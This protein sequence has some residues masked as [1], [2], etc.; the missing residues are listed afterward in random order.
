M[1]QKHILH[2]IPHLGGGLGRVIFAY[3][4]EE[5]KQN[6]NIHY[7]LTLEETKNAVENY[8]DLK[9]YI[10]CVNWRNEIK[11]IKSYINFADI[12]VIH[13]FNHP[14]LFDFMVNFKFLFCRLICY[15]HVSSIFYP[16]TMP[17]NF[18]TFFDKIVFTTAASM[19]IPSVQNFL[20]LDNKKFYVIESAFGAEYVNSNISKPKDEFIIGYI[21]T[22]NHSKLHPNFIYMCSLVKSPVKFVICSNDPQDL[23]KEEIKKFNI[24]DKFYLEGKVEDVKPYLEKFH[25]F[26]YPLQPQHFGSAEQAL[27]ESM[28][29]KAVPIV[30][31]NLAETYIIKHMENGLIVKNEKQ[32]AE[33][34]D[35][36][37]NN[38]E[39]RNKLSENACKFAKERYSIKNNVKK[40]NQVFE[41]LMFQPKT[42]H[43]WTP[44]TKFG[45]LGINL[46]LDSMG[47]KKDVFKNY[48]KNPE[49]EENINSLI[50]FLN[51]N[52]QFN[53][54]RKG[55]IKQYLK[56][57][58][59][60]YN[61][62]KLNNFIDNYQLKD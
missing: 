5:L 34:I 32:Y 24:K 14:L 22:I 7:I 53:L 25:I 13:W 49:K 21:G 52:I 35:F 3:L 46:F 15:N 1:N 58:P 62:I 17:P 4:R 56:Y 9:K 16:Y 44:K 19:E 11:E 60:D 31:N 57:F 6:Q 61:L 8:D 54:D 20:K 10:K 45:S 12:V 51:S 36:L 42:F 26:G 41:E 33:S 59:S 27:G 38:P 47:E 55:G 40:W 50:D 30:F 37:F 18:F 29:Y 39:L 28:V 2:I 48:F 43:K 23:L